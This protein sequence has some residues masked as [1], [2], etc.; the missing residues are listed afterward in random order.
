M[1]AFPRKRYQPHQPATFDL[2]RSRAAS[3][4]HRADLAAQSSHAVAHAA[5]FHPR[6][7]FSRVPTHARAVQMKSAAGQPA[8]AYEREADR[9][10]EQLT[11]TPEPRLQ[12]SCAC[13]GECPKCQGKK[14]GP[15]RGVLQTKRVE[16]GE[17]E[18]TPAP[19]HAEHE[20]ANP[21]MIP[22]L[23]QS[24]GQALDAGARAELEPRFGVDFSTVRVHTGAT[25]AE[26]A[27]ALGARAYTVGPHIV[28]GPGQ[29]RPRTREGY[30]LLAHELAHVVQQRAAASVQLSAYAAEEEPYEREADRAGDDAASGREAKVELNS[31]H[32]APQ[33]GLFSAIKCSYYIWKYSKLQDECRA[34]Y[35]KACGS[36][37]LSEEC[38]AFMG[39]AGFPSDAIMNCVGRKNPQAMR[40]LLKSC[41]KTAAGSYGGSKWTM[42]DAGGDDESSAIAGSEVAGA[43]GEMVG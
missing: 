14:P 13:A 34:E 29:Y 30:R 32:G 10:A 6:Q 25:A 16:Q 39:G 19:P 18:R 21:A 42:N 20:H 8:D 33:F 23:L 4:R 5:A 31:P 28:F 40:D 38:E 35:Q 1:W 2:I 15:K 17:A 24:S 27:A 43:G 36:D 7:D 11:Q 26:S 22:Q 3:P 37:M 12:R 9:I 41:T